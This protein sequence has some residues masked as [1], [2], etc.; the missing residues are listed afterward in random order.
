M[1]E[2]LAFWQAPF[3]LLHSIS[4]TPIKNDGLKPHILD[5]FDRIFALHQILASRRTPIEGKALR[6]KLECS[7]A[8]VT[9]LIEDMRDYLGAPIRYDRERN[10]FHYDPETDPDFELPG[11]W[12]NASELFALLATQKLLADVQPGLLDSQ[13]DPLRE[14][15]LEILRSQR[16]GH[17]DIDRRVRILQI[18]ARPIELAH[19]Q[20][21]ATALLQRRRLRI[22]YHGRARDRTTER[23]VSPQRLVYYRSNWCLDAWCHKAR[24]LRTFSVDR[25]HPVY[26]DDE[27]AKEIDDTLLDAHYARAYGIF[28]G[29]PTETALLRFAPAAAHWVA[30]EQ[31]HPRQQGKALEDGSYELHVP[32]RDPTE[33]LMDVLKYG[34]DVEVIAPA[35]LRSQARDRLRAA[36][37]LYA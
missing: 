12:L 10:G 30:D 4:T 23:D 15:I 36:L 13:L 2:S 16:L 32:Y 35:E 27:P 9:R 21:L 33:L 11:L 8:T 3:H 34:A 28:G 6:E 5:R 18:A 24:G 22:L 7:R 14:R 19:F 37:Q 17:P 31:W 29:E 20:K 26:I 25:L 1:C